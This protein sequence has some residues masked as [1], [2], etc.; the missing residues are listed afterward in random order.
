MRIDIQNL[1]SLREKIR[2]LQEENKKLKSLLRDANILF[3]ENMENMNSESIEYC[4]D[5]G[6]RIINQFIDDR[7]A[8][9]FLTMFQGRRDVYALRGTKGGYFPQCF[10][11][12][13]DICPKQHGIT[14]NCSK[15][16]HRQWKELNLQVGMNHL[17]GYKENCTDVLGVY[18]LLEDGT[19]HF[20][21]F[22]FDNHDKGK[23]TEDYANENGDWKEEVDALRRICKENDIDVLIERSRSGKGAH[24]WIL[25]KEFI[26]ASL[27]RNFG[28]LLLD[29]GATSVNLKTFQY[30][31]RMFPTQEHSEGIGNVIALPLQGKA[32][33]DGNSAFVDENW[34]VYPNQWKILLKETRKL[35]RND[36][37]N[38][39]QKWKIEISESKGLLVENVTSRPKPWKKE[40]SFH[41]EDVVEK[42]SIVLADGVYVDTLNLKPRIQNQIRS[43]AAFDNPN[44]Y[45]NKKMGYSN[46]NQYTAIYMGKDIDDYIKVPR[47][48][49]DRII[50]EC[51]KSKI[52]YN[53]I[54]KRERGKPIK[55]SF[56]GNLKEEQKV[57][58]QK[59]LEYE[60]GVL[61]A[62]T[63]F[64]KTVVSSFLISKKKVNTLILM[65]SV[66]LVEQWVN[67]LHDFLLIDEECPTY[68][69]KS[70]K[71]KVRK[72][73]IGVLHGSKDT[74]TGII[75]V[76][77]V[78]SVYKKG[79]FHKLINS[80]GMVIIDECHHSAS[81]TY[82]QVLEKIN[83]KYV[84]GVSANE[85][86]TDQL[87]K[88]VYMLIGPIRH[89]YTSRQRIEEQTIGHYVYPR[90]T[91]VINMGDTQLDFNNACS[92]I[93]KN[94]V[95]NEMIISDIKECINNKRTPI[96][97]TRYKEHAK[98]IYDQVHNILSHNTFLIYG[99]N[100][101]K[102]NNHMRKQMFDVPENEPL[103]LIAT[104]QS[105]GEGFNFPRLDTLL[106]TTPVSGE[107]LVDQYLG[108][109][110]RDYP[111]KESAIVYDYVDSHIR[112]FNNMYKKRLKAYKKIGYHVMTDLITDKQTPN[113]IYD[114]YDYEEVFEQDIH[115]SNHKVIVCSPQLSNHRV[116]RFIELI[117]PNQ[118]KG[119]EVIVM[120]QD[121]EYIHFGN[122][123]YAYYLIHLL[124][125]NGIYVELCKEINEH[126]AVIDDEII[127]HGGMNLLGKV[128][129]YDNLIRI[130]SK[131]VAIELLEIS[132]RN[133]SR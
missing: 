14:T 53:I 71:T 59:I 54:D 122:L 129:I 126:Y 86:R 102:E 124:K 69:T 106:L 80:Y 11:R 99:N 10:N 51:E 27:A 111:Q 67:E 56:N 65:Q 91:R 62:A 18:P 100:T 128:D 84:Y 73:V 87:E 121:P 41:K 23:E 37:E 130:K 3:E 118:E 45:K 98:Y 78:G 63:A 125:K 26:P 75:D 36:V 113:Y 105:V 127:W 101:L 6:G 108:R 43:L 119:V 38:Y 44:F 93:S 12:W 107:P 131:E 70:G 115:E 103:V 77:T 76:A 39:I 48:L 96:V 94:E 132:F 9:A 46:W 104:A 42:L 20:L 30:Y 21:A 90:F 88:K 58:V 16:S 120:T 97:L 116:T 22:D 114:A 89:Q 2:N 64:G 79:E 85:K 57:A 133:Q 31:D 5:Q 17:L 61:N 29:K 83:A 74:L 13:K 95:R 8:G 66:H 24:A 49:L 68:Q 33:K 82:E 1:D 28:Y 19:C 123:E 40:I 34:N 15:C 32:I 25:F 60:N 47:G 35:T 117:Q 72:D 110:N 81:Y 112:I 50:D 55:V 109:I 52:E 4:E 7:M 92:Y